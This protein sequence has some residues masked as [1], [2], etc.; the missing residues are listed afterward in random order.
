MQSRWLVL[1]Y[2]VFVFFYFS[3]AGIQ[4]LKL[5][6]GEAVYNGNPLAELELGIFREDLSV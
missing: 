1:F 5:A 6:V 4:L 3:N 2:I